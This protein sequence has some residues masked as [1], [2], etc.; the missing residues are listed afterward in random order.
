MSDEKMTEVLLFEIR[1][2]RKQISACREEIGK[3]K[4]DV[5]ANKVK[6]GSIVVGLTFL[7]NLVYIYISEKVKLFLNS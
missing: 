6:L 1:E 5:F 7:G 2:N 4:V 3:L